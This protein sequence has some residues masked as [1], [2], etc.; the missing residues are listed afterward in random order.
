VELDAQPELR[1]IGRLLDGPDAALAVGTRVAL[2]FDPE[3]AFE[4]EGAA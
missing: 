1:L 3:P 2:R 4:L